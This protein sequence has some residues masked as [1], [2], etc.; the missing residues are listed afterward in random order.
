L[1]RIS[2]IIGLLTLSV[3]RLSA[4]NGGYSNL[5]F[6]ENKGQWGSEVKYRAE[7]ST[8]SF[9]LGK[10]GFT[11]VM[12][13]T[14]DLK[15]I[16]AFRHGENHLAQRLAARGKMAIVP[17]SVAEASGLLHSHAYRVSFQNANE[18]SEIVGEKPLDTYN[19]YF[20]GKD[21]TKW[22]SHCRIYQGVTYKN[23]YE[24]IDLRYYT[25][26]GALKYDLIVHP[27]ADPG[28]IALKY[29][30]QD[31]LTIK[32]NQVSIKTSVGT[33]KEWIPRS[34]QLNA[35]EKKDVECSYTL[36][37][38]NTI[39]FKIRNYSPDAT[40]V[41]DP[42]LVFCS[43]TGSKSDN[44]GYTATYDGSGNFY[45]GGIVLAD[46]I[47]DGSGNGYQASPGAF[48]TSFQGGDGTEGGPA[49]T[50]YEYDVAIFK[51]NSTGT[52]RVFATYLGGSGDEQPH[53]MVVD[54]GGNLIVTGRTS[55]PNFPN[56][57]TATMTTYG[58]GGGF[59]I[60]L[61]KFTA[62]GSALIGSRRIGGTG[63]D[64]VNYTP[65]YIEEGTHELRLNYGDDGRSEIIL[66]A[67][68]NI[69]LAGCTQSAD[70]PTTPGVF[71]PNSGGGQD[72]VVMKFSPDISNVFFSS[73]LGGN[74]SDAAFV[75][76]LDPV[77][78][79]I[80]VAGGT[81]SS[82]LLAVAKAGPVL[83]STNQ[84]GIDGFVTV[85]SNDGS[86]QINTTYMGTVGTDIV[87]GIDV[88]KS[89]F[90]YIT[91]STTG[92]WPV[93]NSPY[94]ANNNQK[95]G[96]QYIS[97]LKP[98]LSGWVYST[99]FGKGATFPDLSTTAFLV[100][101]CQNVYVAGW[102]GGI[103]IGE[104]YDNS[105]TTALP[106]TPNAIRTT[107]DGGDFYFFV[108]QRNASAQL[109]GSFFGQVNGALGDHVDGGT[110]RFDKQGIIYEAICANCGGG[111]AFPVSTG[112]VY[113][114]NPVATFGGCN[115]AAVKI[116]FNFAG[117][118]VG[119][120]TN[121]TGRGDSV[122]CIPVNGI[123]QDTVRE[124]TSYIWDFG[125]GTPPLATTS[126]I[127]PHTYN[128]VGTYKIVLTAIDSNSCN[129]TDT[130]F[131]HIT[132]RNDPATLD[133]KYNKIGPCTS[134]EYDFIN[135]SGAPP[136]KPFSGNSFSWDFG[137]NTPPVTMGPG[138]TLHTYL[139]PGTYNVKLSLI[140]T[141]YCNYPG[142]TIKALYIAQNV[143][144]QFTTP[145]SG[146]A[147]YSAV[148]NNTSIAGQQFFWDFGDGSPI[149]SVDRTPPPHLYPTPGPY[150][151]HLRVVDSATCNLTDATQITITVSGSP[152]AA[153]SFA[154][155]P[156]L[157]NTPTVFTNNST[158]GIKYVWLF[159]DGSSETKTTLDTAI[160][161]YNRSGTFNACL[162]AINSFGCPDTVCQ[163][164]AAIVHPLLDVP[165]AFTPGRF[166][167][168]G[169]VKVVGFGITQ[170]T[171][172]IYNR[173]G[174]VVFAS[175]D[176]SIGWD[177]TFKGVIQPMD[178]YAYTLE[179]EFFDG[180]HATRKGDIT[181]I[182]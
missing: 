24:G 127:E 149:D 140:D 178:V 106:T 122:A 97:K 91:G 182:R 54:G 94:N 115:E 128:A 86:N 75:L 134:M 81:Q 45:A 163:P 112:A 132:A 153:F 30:G 46:G 56:F 78:S 53:S 165:N 150:T 1:G 158:G 172:R 63:A 5:E 113:K 49:P 80:F 146:C 73:Y 154:P 13:D 12:R 130:V 155:T 41:I 6:V 23:I 14:T 10:K 40:L 137:D 7:M 17:G 120:K 71:Q 109:Y 42:T 167:Q 51:F 121:L 100:D 62:D 161:Q 135:L 142:D 87:Y 152:A 90:P 31:K 28:K 69:Y 58:T 38:D 47:G 136:G 44:W 148:I 116:A 168:N 59:D 37:A 124:A 18:G 129:I 52:A 119:L 176:P 93:V 96:R 108:L 107:S 177:G 4:Q 133:F 104:G 67:A 29:E 102:G 141:N 77:S 66:D 82:N 147:P 160:H 21:P 43:F 123:F 72:G 19:N 159:G 95:N 126:F 39:R 144:A 22:A 74:S 9:F 157:E 162:V 166:G 125:D 25:D 65:K 139:A 83:Y 50:G 8:G 105:N 34:Y 70:F 98:D 169:I 138:D 61:T 118:S 145:A 79:N 110:S 26:G 92:I 180:T 84:G 2:F 164:V 64:G 179:A 60:F 16:Q 57:P 11:V 174:Q 111:A 36:S 181:L 171:F 170:L 89:G 32:K 27:G 151:I 143:K 55:S 15:R 156:P 35:T 85:I 88:D 76:A 117:V 33:V 173:W 175:S 20:I 68:N 101:R 114:T 48:Q 103:D 131:L 99:V 3:F